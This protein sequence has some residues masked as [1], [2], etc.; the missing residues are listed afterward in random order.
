MAR[1]ETKDGQ[2]QGTKAK[3]SGSE[4]RWTV[5]V[6][7]SSKRADCGLMGILQRHRRTTLHRDGGRCAYGY[8]SDTQEGRAASRPLQQLFM[9]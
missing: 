1:T 3:Q 8:C 4:L 7:S 9:I 6:S 5:L 2:H